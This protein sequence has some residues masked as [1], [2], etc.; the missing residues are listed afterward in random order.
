[1]LA[2]H[3]AACAARNAISTA[4]VFGV[5]FAIGFRPH[6]RALNWLAAAALLLFFTLAISWLAATIGIKAK[7]P[8]G[9]NGFSFFVMF[10]PYASS[11]FAPIK[12]MPWWIPGFARH[13]PMTPVIEVLRGL[14]L[15][16]PVGA[17]LWIATL[18]CAAILLGS[19]ALSGLFFRRRMG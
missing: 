18:W 2:G 19:M 11:A 1:M 4:L 17:N 16:T 10:L 3:V 7:S 8:E 13:Q 9:A 5:A 14:P 15:G 6:A 12:T